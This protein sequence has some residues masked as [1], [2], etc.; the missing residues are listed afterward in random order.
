MP[1]GVRLAWAWARAPARCAWAHVRAIQTHEFDWANDEARRNW[2]DAFRSRPLEAR[3]VHIVYAR[4]SGPGGQNVNKL[5]TKVHARLDLGPR[6]PRPLPAGLVKALAKQSPMYIQ[7]TH[8]LQVASERHRSQAQNVQDA[9]SKL[10]A[11]ILRLGS[12]GLRGATSPEQQERVAQ[13]A[14]REREHVRRAK[15]MRSLTKRGRREKP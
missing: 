8:S 4:S 6:T 2:L 11:E 13:L 15:Q 9:L 12:A 14:K 10:H 7:A 3:E 5:H 1:G